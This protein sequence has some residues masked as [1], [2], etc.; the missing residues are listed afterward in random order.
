VKY[1]SLLT[2]VNPELNRQTRP[3][4]L[5]YISELYKQGKVF[6]AGPYGDGSGGAVIYEC[7]TA[8]EAE[9]LAHLDPAVSS[10]AR[11]VKVHPWNPL[12]LPVP[13]V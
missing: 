11:T 10:G 6:M 12:E 8:Q 13:S 4:H 1:L 3:D 5:H 9:E 2:I 7:T